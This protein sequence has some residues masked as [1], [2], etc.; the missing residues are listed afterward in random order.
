MAQ[1]KT[2][3]TWSELSEAKKRSALWEVINNPG[4][5]FR[6]NVSNDK[7]DSIIMQTKDMDFNE[8]ADSIRDEVYKLC[9]SF[10]S[11]AK[12]IYLVKKY[13]RIED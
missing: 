11:S 5:G 12:Q 4:V 9:M 1:N 7:V 2:R 10:V 6:E 8:K 3:K 13:L